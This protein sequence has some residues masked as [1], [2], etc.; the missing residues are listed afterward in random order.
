M[1]T[2]PGHKPCVVLYLLAK[3]GITPTPHR[4]S[5]HND[6][7]NPVY[8]QHTKLCAT[9]EDIPK[10]QVPVSELHWVQREAP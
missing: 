2:H 3:L 10:L 4:F 5:C 9:A 6:Q 8:N 7:T 1:K